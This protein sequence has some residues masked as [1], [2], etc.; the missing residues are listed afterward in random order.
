M[1]GLV[2]DAGPGLAGIGRVG[3]AFAVAAVASTLLDR[4]LTRR[5]QRTAPTPAPAR[6]D[7]PESAAASR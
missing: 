7:V 6:R 5:H 4:H 1:S 2:I 3:A